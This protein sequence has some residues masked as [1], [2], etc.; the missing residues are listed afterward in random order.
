VSALEDRSMFHLL[1]FITTRLPLSAACGASLFATACSTQPPGRPAASV[2][3]AAGNTQPKPEYD[4]KG[5]LQKIEY[6]RNNDGRVD[7]W[8]YMDGAR[9]VRVEVDENGDGQVDRWEYHTSNAASTSPV[10][11]VDAT[12]ERIERATK[13]D[14][15]ISRKEYFTG[16]VLSQIEE[17]TNGDGRMDK[18]ETYADGSLSVLLLDTHGRGTPDRRLVYRPD[19]SLARMEA[20][21]AGSGTFSRVAR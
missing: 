1:R 2:S 15:Q 18:W 21:N 12:L 9:V 17:D 19:G 11:G 5:K 4:D 10:A 16:G 13:F 14:G 8:G 7:T 20:D 6:D 3:Q